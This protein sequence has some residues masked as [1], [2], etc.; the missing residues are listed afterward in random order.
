MNSPS[1]GSQGHLRLSP[2]S[3]APSS[4]PRD[5]QQTEESSFNKDSANPYNSGAY[6]AQYL[7]SDLTGGGPPVNRAWR[8][9]HTTASPLSAQTTRRAPQTASPLL[10][11]SGI[12]LAS[13]TPATRPGPGPGPCRNHPAA[14]KPNQG[15]SSS[16]PR[17]AHRAGAA[18]AQRPN[19]SK[20]A[21]RPDHQS[22]LEREAPAPPSNSRGNSAARR[23]C[24]PRQR[25]QEAAR[26]P[27]PQASPDGEA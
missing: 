13:S 21:I 9:V 8:R 7:R 16:R 2:L 4:P 6:Q 12:K 15:S 27:V 23:A 26:P 11:Y 10:D 25:G 1:S 3:A 18:V 22:G 14:V 17:L 20:A 24:Q 5:H 19:D